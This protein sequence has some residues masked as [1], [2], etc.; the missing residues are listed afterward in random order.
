MRWYGHVKRMDEKRMMMSVFEN[1]LI[2]VR[3]VV[4]L[5][6]RRIDSEREILEYNCGPSRGD[7]V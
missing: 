3:R 7:R 6:N 4:R 1:E 2:G 5:H